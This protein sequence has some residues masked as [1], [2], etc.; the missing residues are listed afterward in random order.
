LQVT[1]HLQNQ[2]QSQPNTET[3]AHIVTLFVDK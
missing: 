2:L 1:V 3:I